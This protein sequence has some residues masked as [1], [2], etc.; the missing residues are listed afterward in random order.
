MSA[1]ETPVLHQLK[2]SHYNEK[3]RWALDYKRVPHVRRS[4]FPGQQRDAARE[5]AGGSTLPVL[6]IDGQAFPDST[7]II[8]ALEE[9][10]PDPPLYPTDRG[11]RRRALELEDDFDEHLGP[12][13]RRIV[14][15]ELSADPELLLEVI[16]D[17]ADDAVRDAMRNGFPAV[18]QR[19]V[20]QFGLTDER[21]ERDRMTLRAAAEHA[22]RTRGD[23]DYLVG[24]RFTVAD[25]TL[26]ALVYPLACPPQAPYAHPSL[27]G[28]SDEAMAGLIEWVRMIYERHRPRSAE[29]T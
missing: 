8:A 24:D 20:D 19:L 11:E 23:S 6:V 4:V 28:G 16:G 12:A 26:A 15:S 21:L 18:S 10:H 17:D 1:L 27:R 25:L 13:A 29:I 3:A 2:F 7:E 14:M 5:L 22:S 9:R